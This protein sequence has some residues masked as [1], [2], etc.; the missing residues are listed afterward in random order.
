MQG[1]KWWEEL[2]HRSNRNLAE[3][4]AVN[5]LQHSPS[6]RNRPRSQIADTVG[7]GRFV[8]VTQPIGPRLRPWGRKNTA[9]GAGDKVSA[10]TAEISI[11]TLIVTAN[12]G[13]A[14]PKP[15]AGKR[16]AR[17]PRDTSYLPIV[18]ELN[19]DVDRGGHDS[20]ENLTNCLVAVP[21][22]SRK[23]PAHRRYERQAGRF[24]GP[25]W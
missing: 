3:S 11:A 7:C 15:P 23:L 4:A 21:Q 20:Q 13:T 19:S 22:S 10:L 9:H 25:T 5:K 1:P 2:R 12:S 16:P 6:P 17:T 24:C 18:L 14:F 8:V